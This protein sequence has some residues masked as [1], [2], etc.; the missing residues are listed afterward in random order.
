M[1]PALSNRL[2]R[3]CLIACMLF[4]LW[5]FVKYTPAPDTD[6]TYTAVTGVGLD[7]NTLSAAYDSAVLKTTTASAVSQAGLDALYT[8]MALQQ[9]T[10]VLAAAGITWV[11]A[12]SPQL[13]R[14][15]AD[16][17]RSDGYGT[18]STGTGLPGISYV[19]TSPC[20]PDRLRAALPD[21]DG[22]YHARV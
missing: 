14:A 21:G 1:G 6:A 20:T 8:S 17:L 19:I 22:V 5:Q 15:T 4:A 7:L 3:L 11:Q 10:G 12:D 18:V 13:A 9:F 16:Q 2:T